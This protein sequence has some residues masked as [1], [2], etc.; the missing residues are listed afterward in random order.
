MKKILC[1][2]LVLC[3]FSA[4]V[5]A[6]D[7]ATNLQRYNSEK[8]DPVAASLW[9]LFV[10]GGGQYYNGD[11]PRAIG[12]ASATGLSFL[13]WWYYG[14][15]LHNYSTANIYGAIYLGTWMY[16]IYDA[17]VGAVE[18]NRKLKTKYGISSIELLD[19]AMLPA[20]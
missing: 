16:S 11:L 4:F 8:K 15:H 20:F 10:G 3:F 7:E 6:G 17:Q 14:F 2:F 13:L 19:V 18:I 12:F 1:V 5:Y 9:S